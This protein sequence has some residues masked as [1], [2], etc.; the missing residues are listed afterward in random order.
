MKNEPIVTQPIEIESQAILPES[1]SI[2]KVQFDRFRY[3]TRRT[4]YSQFHTSPIQLR[5]D[6][7]EA[8]VNK[9]PECFEDYE[10]RGCFN[11]WV[12]VLALNSSRNI[13]KAYLHHNRKYPSVR[14]SDLPPSEMPAGA[15]TPLDAMID[16]E[17]SIS[18]PERVNRIL[19]SLSLGQRKVIRMRY[20]FDG[21]EKSVA[22]VANA[23][24]IP[25][26]T[27]KT[28]SAAAMNRLRELLKTEFSRNY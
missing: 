23:L 7:V 27:I 8:A 20:G 9:L 21:P 1:Y 2:T 6:M 24:G 13:A 5:R 19:N 10:E 14:F 3:V 15:S 4:I 22:E 28:R 25:I 16:E 11:G 26:G 18:H 12:T 17:E